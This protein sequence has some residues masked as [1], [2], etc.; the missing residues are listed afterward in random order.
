MAAVEE[1]LDAGFQEQQEAMRVAL[2]HLRR[3]EEANEMITKLL[4]QWQGVIT[5]EECVSTALLLITHACRTYQSATVHY[6]AGSLHASIKENVRKVNRILMLHQEP[7]PLAVYSLGSIV[8][9]YAED[10]GPEPMYRAVHQLSPVGPMIPVGDIRFTV[11]IVRT[12]IYPRQI[13][14]R[15]NEYLKVLTLTFE[16]TKENKEEDAKEEEVCPCPICFDTLTLKDIVKTNCHHG[17]C[18]DCIKNMTTS[19]KDNTHEPTCPLCRT[20]ITGF[21]IGNQELCIEIKNHLQ[22]L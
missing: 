16:D 17:Y 7:N 1:E 8:L 19:I 3:S 22:L 6:N 21:T 11:D 12:L 18:T 5:I 15:T 20:T 4:T 13:V 14:K 9:V 2:I 10:N